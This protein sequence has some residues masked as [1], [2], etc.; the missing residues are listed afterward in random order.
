MCIAV[1]VSSSQFAYLVEY[2]K[3]TKHHGGIKAYEKKKKYIEQY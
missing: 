2:H 3:K 1:K